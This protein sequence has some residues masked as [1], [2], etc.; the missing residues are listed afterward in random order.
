MNTSAQI[1]SKPLQKIALSCSGGG[2]RASSFHLGTM[3]YLNRL[4]YQKKPLLEKVTMI[5]TVSGGTITGVIY[6]QKKQE[7]KTFDEIYHFILGRL[8]QLDLVKI[9]LSK[10]N[11]GSS[12]TNKHKR[13]NLINAFSEIYDDE[14]TQGA[15]FEIFKKMKSHLEAVVFNST[16]FN[17]GINFRFRNNGRSTFGNGRNDVKANNALEVKL[18]DAI[19]A[20]SCFP[21]GFE[22]IVWPHDFVHDKS[23]LLAEL[24]TNHTP[25]GI[26][27]GGIYDNQGIDSILLYKADHHKKEGSKGEPYF[28]LIIVS[29]V[30]SPDMTAFNPKEDEEK[31]G[32]LSWTVEDAI[33]KAKRL[34]QIIDRT[35]LGLAVFL[36]VLPI[37][38]GFP[39]NILTGICLAFGFISTAI[40]LL[41]QALLKKAESKI[42]YFWNSKINKPHFNFYLKKLAQLDYKKLSLRRLDPLVTDR[43]NSVLV[44]LTDVFL[45][46]VRSLNYKIFYRNDL[47]QF[48]RISSLIKELA[49][50]SIQDKKVVDED[51]EKERNTESTSRSFFGG[52]LEEAIGDKIQDVAKKAS[53]VGTSLWF[54]DEEQLDNILDKLVATGQFTMCYNMIKYLETL[55]YVKGNG[56]SNLDTATK[57][58]LHLLYDQC[59]TDWLKF[60]EDPL[61]M[62]E[63][64]SANA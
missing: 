13:K 17:T 34:N 1:P 57:K 43:L 28:D 9:G 55:F 45:K 27:D 38:F 5:S 63:E 59:K 29:D 35:T 33:H 52:P 2:Y 37:L 62:V 44:L 25:T 23:N 54:T 49:T 3:S 19:A 24:A 51:D 39:N 21:G 26:M 50:K 12:W 30:A 36:L 60:K 48:R 46:I 64:M 31:T 10:L 6:A 15:T 41:K 32:I 61:F 11:P 42:M 58:E 16:E 47:Y 4:N 14:F 56:Y 22:P 8:R 20:S 40:Y 7:G 18:A 53:N